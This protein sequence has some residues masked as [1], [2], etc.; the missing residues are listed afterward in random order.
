MFFV[1]RLEA[2]FVVYVFIYQI[3]TTHC[4][5]HE[6]LSCFNHSEYNTRDI[7]KL[8][9]CCFCGWEQLLNYALYYKVVMKTKYCNGSQSSN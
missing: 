1:N 5:Q 7:I 4:V 2:L 3:L 6:F 8:C 9:T